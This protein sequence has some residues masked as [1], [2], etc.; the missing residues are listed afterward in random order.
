MKIIRPVTPDGMCGY[1]D[2]SQFILSWKDGDTT[3][4]T[5]GSNTLRDTCAICLRGWEATSASLRDQ[6]RWPL[7]DAYVHET[8]LVRHHGFIE[9]SMFSRAISK[10]RLAHGGLRAVDNQYWGNR[11]PWGKKPWYEADLNEYAATVVLGWRKNVAHVE[12]R[13]WPGSSANVEHVQ[14]LFEGEDVT[15]DFSVG[16]A[17]IHAWGDAKVEEYLVRFAALLR[18]GWLTTTAAAADESRP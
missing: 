11:D 6:T 14:K 9:R 1:D 3:T 17:W 7:I 16:S 12:V 10:A 15:K 8:C 4:S 18:T 2:R 5:F 13:V